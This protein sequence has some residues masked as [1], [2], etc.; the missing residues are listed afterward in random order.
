MILKKT[1][2]GISFKFKNGKSSTEDSLKFLDFLLNDYNLIIKT[3]KKS[4]RW[5]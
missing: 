1:K 5:I 3:T 2:K 4:K